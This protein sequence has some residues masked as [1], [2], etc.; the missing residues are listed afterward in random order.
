MLFGPTQHDKGS[1]LEP[2]GVGSKAYWFDKS[3]I[4]EVIHFNKFAIY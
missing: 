2:P 4:R 1:R 3:Q